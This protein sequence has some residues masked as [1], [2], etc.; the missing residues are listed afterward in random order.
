M[1]ESGANDVD[2]EEGATSGEDKRVSSSSAIEEHQPDNKFQLDSIIK[3]YVESVEGTIGR[4]RENIDWRRGR[5]L[6]ARS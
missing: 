6:A 1:K 3:D 2:D 4:L 5:A